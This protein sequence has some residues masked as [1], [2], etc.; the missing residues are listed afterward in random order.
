MAGDADWPIIRFMITMPSRILAAAA[1]LALLTSCSTSQTSAGT[2]AAD[3]ELALPNCEQ[4]ATAL[5]HR[6]QGYTLNP[7]NSKTEPDEIRCN[8]NYG[9]RYL[10]G[11]SVAFSRTERDF[12]TWEDLPAHERIPG[13]ER[14]EDPLLDGREGYLLR[15]GESPMEVTQWRAPS[16]QMNLIL[17]GDEADEAATVAE[18]VGLLDVI[19]G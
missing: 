11:I 12:V 5:A 6:M 8:W 7:E 16:Y 2:D 19:E 1:T 4:I 13:L 14:I 15:F 18:V 17:Q 10:D 3:T 9:G